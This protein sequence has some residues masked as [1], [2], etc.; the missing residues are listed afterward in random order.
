MSHSSPNPRSVLTQAKRIVIKM[1]STQL[2]DEQGRPRLAVIGS[3]AQ[4]IQTLLKE[5]KEIVFVTSGAVAAG[6]T[7]LGDTIK[8]LPQNPS[9]KQACAAI[10][11]VILMNLYSRMFELLGICVSQVLLTKDILEHKPCRENLRLVFENLL[12]CKVLPIVNENDSIST[13]EIEYIAKFG[14]NDNLASVVAILIQADVLILL[15]DINGLYDRDPTL[16]SNAQ[17]LDHIEEITQ[18]ILEC[19]T[20]SLSVHGTGGMRT[21]IEAAKRVMENQCHMV[22]ANG[23]EP[24]I[25]HRILKGEVVGSF[26]KAN[27]YSS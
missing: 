26:F 6:A 27:N 3:L 18:K 5:D 11:Q 13:Q 14:D 12:N 21:K 1:G 17:F 22:I 24:N 2:I 16:H 7:K 25:L 20:D 4:N 10:G 19:A 8:Q 23:R 15:S 9:T